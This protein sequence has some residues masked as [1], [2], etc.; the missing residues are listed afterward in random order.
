MTYEA[1]NEKVSNDLND[2]EMTLKMLEV[3]KIA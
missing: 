3:T 2:L 1:R